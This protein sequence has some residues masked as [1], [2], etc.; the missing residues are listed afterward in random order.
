MSLLAQAKKLASELDQSRPLALP[1]LE[2]LDEVLQYRPRPPQAEMDR[3]ERRF[4]SFVTHRR[5]GKTVREV[6][7][8]IRRAMLCPF[9]EGR[10]AYLAPTYQMAEDIAWTYLTQ[11]ATRIYEHAGLDPK[12][13]LNASRLALWLPTYNGSRSRI[14]LYGVD[15]PKQRLRGLYL[16]GVSFDEWAQIPFSVWSEQVRPMLADENRAGVD[17]EGRINQWADFITTPFGRNHAYTMHSKADAW[18]RGQPVI[19]KD[20][21]TGQDHAVSRDD[22]CAKLFKASETGVLT[23]REL[24]DAKADMGRSKYEQEFECS[25]DAAVEGAIFAREIEEARAQ[26]RIRPVPWN[27]LVPVNTSWDLGHDDATAIWFFQHIGDQV[28]IIDYHEEIGGSP[29]TCADVLADKGY[30][31]GYHLFPHDVG[32][33][34]WGM[35]RDRISILRALGIRVTVVPKKSKWDQIAAGQA[36]FSKCVFDETR[37]ARGV[38]ALALYRREKNERLGVFRENPVHDEFSHGADAFMVM[39]LGRRRGGDS[40]SVFNRMTS[41]QF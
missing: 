24:A 12:N 18:F 22:W 34:H 40:A 9:T 10:Y 21:D 23:T 17:A 16:D 38:D 19:E 37:C 26:N 14:R 25:W 6:R 27:K 20:Q 11:F 7:K 41:A 28:N 30:R 3:D 32:Q 4:N 13:Y 5:L 1:P 15:S 39:A 2:K 29:D 36:V 31:Y 35:E 33:T 8:L